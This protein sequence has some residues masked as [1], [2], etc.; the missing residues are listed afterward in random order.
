MQANNSGHSFA[1]KFIRLSVCNVYMFLVTN[2][3]SP[4][5]LNTTKSAIELLISHCV[6]ISRTNKCL[7]QRWQIFRKICQE[8]QISRCHAGD[9][10]QAT[11][12]APT[13]ISATLHNL[14]AHALCNPDP[15]YNNTSAS[16]CI[17]FLPPACKILSVIIGSVWSCIVSHTSVHTAQRT[18]FIFFIKS[19][20]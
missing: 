16:V 2:I 20:R 7:R 19:G 5:N 18:Q 17:C 10:Q 3:L 6:L 13:N 14:V 8:R 4:Y 12:S 11:S 15:S 1:S 9:M